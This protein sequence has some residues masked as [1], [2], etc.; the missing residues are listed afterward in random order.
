MPRRGQNSH[1]CICGTCMHNFVAQCDWLI[2]ARVDAE[3]R[4]I[5]EI[6]TKPLTQEE[7]EH[8]RHHLKTTWE[9]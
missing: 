8:M 2:D 1:S 5:R 4:R 6:S 3:K 9:F 7:I